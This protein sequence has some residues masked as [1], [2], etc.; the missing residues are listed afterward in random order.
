VA[1]EEYISKIEATGKL[2]IPFTHPDRVDL[3]TDTS[4]HVYR[5]LQEVIHNCIKHAQASQVEIRMEQDDRLLKI[6]CRDNGKGFDYATASKGIGLNSLKNRTEI[7]GG[8]M[9]LESK[10]GKGTAFLFEIPLK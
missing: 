6:W 8:K 7:L 3:P 1:V 10:P 5:A 4:I 2:R 9:T